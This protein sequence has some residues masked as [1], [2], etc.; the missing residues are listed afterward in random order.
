V[1]R[2]A[3]CREVFA[4]VVIT[5]AG[6]ERNAALFRAFGAVPRHVFVGPGPWV[7]SEDGQRTAWDDPAM[8]YHDLGLGIGPGIPTGLPSLHAQLLDACAVQAGERVV[9]VGAGTGYFTAILAELVGE[10]GRVEAYEIDDTLAARATENLKS[11]PWVEVKPASA[12]AA[13]PGAADLIYVNAGVQALPRAWLEALAPGGRL[14]LPLVPGLAEGGVFLVTRPR[15]GAPASRYGAR[16]V[17]PARF[18]PCIGADDEATSARLARAYSRGGVAAVRSLI[19][20]PPG[21]DEG[22]WFGGDGFWLTT[23]PA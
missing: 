5:K 21:P 23:S 15:Q 17:C 18:V 20:A 3:D 2:L 7:V 12:V 19:L 13:T 4:K 8:A 1:E 11:W 10:R 22:V 16:H 6:C 14:L 9:Q